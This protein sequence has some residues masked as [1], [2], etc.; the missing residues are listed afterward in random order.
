MLPELLCEI[1]EFL[2]LNNNNQSLKTAK[3]PPR[4]QKNTDLRS[5]EYLSQPEVDE[6]R[7][8]ARHN[9]RHR[10]LSG[11]QRAGRSAIDPWEVLFC[12]QKI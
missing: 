10:I 6:L 3:L 4:K 12:L 1:K 11:K 7:Q 9:G 2:P 5:R 8:A